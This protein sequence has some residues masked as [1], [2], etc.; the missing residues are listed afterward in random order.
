M[1]QNDQDFFEWLVGR[2]PEWLGSAG[3]DDLKSAADRV[4]YLNGYLHG[5]YGDINVEI[6]RRRAR[7]MRVY[8]P[9][10]DEFTIFGL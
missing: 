1:I 6:L 8:E 5:R 10:R 7:K 3:L 9:P 2:N 4:R